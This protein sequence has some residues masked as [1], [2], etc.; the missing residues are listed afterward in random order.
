MTRRAELAD[1]LCHLDVIARQLGEVRESVARYAR[2]EDICPAKV[3]SVDGWQG[4]NSN[5][6]DDLRGSGGR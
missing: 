5:A 1:L 4:V 2:V 6:S 3:H